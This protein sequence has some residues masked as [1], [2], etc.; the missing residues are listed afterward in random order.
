[1]D[2]RMPQMV[3]LRGS[4]LME[5]VLGGPY[6]IIFAALWAIDVADVFVGSIRHHSHL[7][8]LPLA[9]RTDLVELTAERLCS[10]DSSVRPILEAGLELLRLVEEIGKES[11]LLSDEAHEG[12]SGAPR[13]LTTTGSWS[14]W[15]ALVTP[16]SL[17]GGMSLMSCA[18]VPWIGSWPRPGRTDMVRRPFW[19]PRCHCR[20]LLL[21]APRARLIR[22]RP[23]GGRSL[24]PIPPVGVGVMVGRV[25]P[26]LEVVRSPLLGDVRV[27]RW[28]LFPYSLGTGPPN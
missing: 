18:F 8:R 21:R 5:E 23:F 9:L 12:S 24:V 3:A 2:A 25:G 7:W 11:W 10:A 6:H 13:C 27:R 19:L 28:C 1:M 4:K 17:I 22:L 20:R 26:T 14:L 15:R 16:L